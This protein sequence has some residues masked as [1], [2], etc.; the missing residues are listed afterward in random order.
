MS[1][2]TRRLASSAPR[3][4]TKHGVSRS[5]TSIARATSAPSAA[6]ALMMTF[7]S[8][9]DVPRQ[10]ALRDVGEERIRIHLLHVEHAGAL[11]H[12]GH[13]HRGA[14]HGRDAGG[15]RHRLGADLAVGL[16][17]VADVVDEVALALAVL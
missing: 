17:V 2:R 11:P 1:A 5:R 13:H 7:S 4:V 3:S 15:V 6:P 16:G 10:A 8:L 9:L 12:A 14:G